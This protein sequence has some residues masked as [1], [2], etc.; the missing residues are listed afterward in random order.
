M[1]FKEINVVEVMVNRGAV[2]R[3]IQNQESFNSVLVL[4]VFIGMLVLALTL[5]FIEID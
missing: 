4:S 2:E 5:L 1:K 3:H